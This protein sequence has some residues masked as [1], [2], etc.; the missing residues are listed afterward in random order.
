DIKQ[1]WRYLRD[2][3]IKAKKKEHQYVPSGSAT[4]VSLRKRTLFRFYQQ[5]KFLNDVQVKSV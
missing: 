5:M 1:R 3:Y 2:C 4:D